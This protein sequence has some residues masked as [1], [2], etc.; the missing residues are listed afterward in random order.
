MSVGKLVH[1]R[2]RRI[3]KAKFFAFFG[4]AIVFA[5]WSWWTTLECEPSGPPVEQFVQA[6]PCT[7][8]QA[9]GIATA[10]L[11]LGWV[12]G[13][14]W[15]DWSNGPPGWAISLNV[16]AAGSVA[17]AVVAIAVGAAALVGGAT[18]LFGVTWGDQSSLNALSGAA[19]LLWLVFVLGTFTAAVWVG[20]LAAG[21]T[22][23]G[24][25][26]LFSSSSTASGIAVGPAVAVSAGV[27][28][29]VGAMIVATAVA[30]VMFYVVI[31][32]VYVLMLAV[33]FGA[34]VSAVRD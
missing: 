29:A 30:L 6:V 14:M 27:A 10:V 16:F 7:N 32:S 2:Q 17:F 1:K 18:V 4:P 11:I 19:N 24:A 26:R 15:R 9:A 22:A 3:G 13:S 20:V 28:A 34:A 25:R 12:Y 23:K 21:R 8:T 33:L 31:Y 5:G